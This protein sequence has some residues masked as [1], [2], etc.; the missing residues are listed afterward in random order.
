MVKAHASRAKRVVKRTL[1]DMGQPVRSRPLKDSNRRTAG[2]PDL[3]TATLGKKA[4]MP[5]SIEPCKP[6]L[7][8]QA[9]SGP[10]WLHEI[11]YDGYRLVAFKS[12]Q[13]LQLQ[14]KTGLNWTDRF[15]GVAEALL[16]VPMSQIVL[17][18][19]A[20][21]EGTD[22]MPDF[23]A[24]QAALGGRAGTRPADEVILYAFD[25]L[26]LNGRDLRDEPLEVRR[27]ALADVFAKM[28]PHPNLR[29]SEHSE[30]DGKTI[31]KHAC[32]MGL[33]GIV[34]KR[35]DQPYRSGPS[36][37]W[38]KTKCI[39][40]DTFTIVGYL[41]EG[42]KKRVGALL[43][44]REREGQLVYAGKAGSGLNTEIA[45]KLWHVLEADRTHAQP[46]EGRP[47]R[48]TRRKA[49]WVDPKLRAEVEHRGMTSDGKLRHPVFKAIAE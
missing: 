32:Q 18:G 43:L 37:H 12:A 22:G 46:C 13:K 24:L 31:W 27:Q 9:P 8:Q 28:T 11:K 34:S 42:T 26:Y 19:E 25:L 2:Q 33:E 39:R 21:V 14:T 47:S 38:L 3:F 29:F 6:T 49:R 7:V 30:G 45:S 5:T 15:P 17:D 16:E 40:N 23:G 35:R 1:D 4:P 41:P 10:E 20:V 44:A 48:E 36:T